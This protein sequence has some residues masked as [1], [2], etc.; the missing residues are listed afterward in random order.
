MLLL[1]RQLPL[2]ANVLQL[3][4]LLKDLTDR[5]EGGRRMKVRERGRKRGLEEGY[6]VV[7]KGV[8]VATSQYLTPSKKCHHFKVLYN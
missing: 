1:E 4:A 5:K 2:Q 3:G 7:L 8:S 6:C